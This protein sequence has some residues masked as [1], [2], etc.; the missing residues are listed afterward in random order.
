MKTTRRAF[1]AASAAM[2]LA[3]TARAQTTKVS[4]GVTGAATDVG[5]WVADAKGFFK[6]EGIEVNFERFDSAARMN[7]VLGSGE[8]DVGAG[9]P[10]AGLFNEIGRAHV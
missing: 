4:I 6:A 2:G 8:L 7:A 3:G 5:L 10:S 1:L 9:G